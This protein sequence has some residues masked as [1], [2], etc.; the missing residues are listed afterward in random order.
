MIVPQFWAEGRAQFREK[1]KSV[2]VRRFG[3]SDA[4]EAEA[5]ANADARA[6]EALRRVLSGEKLRRR[7]PKIPYNGADGMPIRE[8]IVARHGDT[9]ITRNSYGARCLNTPDVLFADVDFETGSTEPFSCI[10]IA[11]A[12]IAAITL[13]IRLHYKLL[14]FGLGIAAIFLSHFIAAA[15]HR[16]RQRTKGDP[17]IAARERIRGFLAKHPDWSLRIYRTPAGLRVLAMHSTFSP[18]DPAVAEF[19]RALG[20]DRVYVRMCTNQ[21]CFRARVS[22]KP[23]RIGIP[24]HM[25]PRPGVWPVNPERLP[26]RTAWLEKYDAAAKAFAACALLETLGSGAMHPKARAVQELHDN[27]SRATAGLPMA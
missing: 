1:K 13:G 18:R 19:F 17:L 10:F 25:R 14:A 4:S 24:D 9:I 27:L 8:E 5:Q 6:Q 26:L 23:W 7:E 15:F 3:W 12:F 16:I 21:H 2:T 11:V 20:T 22:A